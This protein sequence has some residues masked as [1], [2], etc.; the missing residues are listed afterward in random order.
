MTGLLVFLGS[1]DLSLSP[2]VHVHENLRV[3]ISSLY[4]IAEFL[5]QNAQPRDSKWSCWAYCP[6]QTHI[7]Y[8]IGPFIGM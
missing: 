1:T 7:L 6:V 3:Q 4:I 5:S 2:A 8:I